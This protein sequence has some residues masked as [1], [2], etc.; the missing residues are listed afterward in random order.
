M[1]V[2]PCQTCAQSRPCHKRRYAPAVDACINCAQPEPSSGDDDVARERGNE[3]DGL[4][5]LGVAAAQRER[6]K[7]V[8]LQPGHLLRE[9]RARWERTG[10]SG[11]PAHCPSG[12]G[13]AP[14]RRVREVR[15]AQR[16]A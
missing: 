8:S 11:W 3:R 1:V 14:G 7:R 5:A 15:E 16:E 6:M 12:Q 2:V 10:A 9:A 4:V 13:P